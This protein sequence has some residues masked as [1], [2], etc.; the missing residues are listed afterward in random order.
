MASGNAVLRRVDSADGKRYVE[1]RAHG[2]LF[3]FEEFAEA[4]DGDYT[5]IAPSHCSGLYATSS[6]AERDMMAELPWLRE[7][8]VR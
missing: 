3:V 1:L 5:F 7:G 6:E 8:K 2:D 4:T